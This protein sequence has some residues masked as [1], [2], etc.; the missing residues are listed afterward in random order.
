MYICKPI[1]FNNQLAIATYVPWCLL[2]SIVQISTQMYLQ[3]VNTCLIIVTRYLSII[4]MHVC[5]CICVCVHAYMC[6]CVCGVCVVCV[7]LKFMEA[8]YSIYW[9][10]QINVLWNIFIDRLQYY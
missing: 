4:Y 10:V 2:P 6:V 5:V 1:T 7:Y 9:L 3:P 8:G